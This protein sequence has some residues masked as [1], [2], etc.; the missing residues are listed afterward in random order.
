MELEKGEDTDAPLPQ[1]HLEGK[2]FVVG[3][4]ASLAINHFGQPLLPVVVK[5]RLANLIRTQTN[6]IAQVQL[7]PGSGNAD[8]DKGII[9]IQYKALVDFQMQRPEESCQALLA[10]PASFTGAMMF[11]VATRPAAEDETGNQACHELS[12][13]VKYTLGKH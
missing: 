13:M 3:R 11:F 2:I 8:A 7:A 12:R 5:A 6:F 10:M 9:M 4:W 1:K